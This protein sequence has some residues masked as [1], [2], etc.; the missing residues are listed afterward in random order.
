M[1]AHPDQ[2]RSEPNESPRQ[3]AR[4][5]ISSFLGATIEFYDFLLYAQAAVLAF[6]PV[7]FR[8]S[9]PEV[10][11][12]AALGTFATG[13]LARPLGGLVFGYFGDRLGRKKMLILS[14][15]TMGLASTAIGLIPPPTVIGPWA[16]VILV[17]LRVC[18]GIAVG[19]EWGGATLLAYEHAGVKRRGFLASFTQAGAPTGMALA[20]LMLGLFAYLP[21][22][23]FQSWGWRI[24]FLFSIVLLALCLFVR[25]GVNESPEFNTLAKR[26]A[27]GTPE[28]NRPLR[29]VFQ[30]PRP[31]L[32]CIFG[33]LGNFVLAGMLETF[34]LAY[35]V[36]AG[37]P[38]HEALVM[39]SAASVFLI[40]VT[41][42][43]GYLS[44]LVGRVRLMIIGYLAFAALLYPVFYLFSLADKFAVLGALLLTKVVHGMIYGPLAAFIADQFRPEIRYVG[45]SAGYQVASLLGNGLGPLAITGLYA[46]SGQNVVPVVAVGS[47][48]C[49]LSA[50]VVFTSRFQRD[51]ERRSP[52][53]PGRKCESGTRT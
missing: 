49:L 16:A 45:A 3:P 7:F 8:G 51:R 40:F 26:R 31:V 33:T 50:I 48:C 18:Q 37:T 44:D 6:G 53:I 19:G 35:A 41:V 47:G 52:S 29:D 32:I 13:Y 43:M 5:A 2:V 17:F 9:P 10:A 12:I 21:T 38:K 1:S 46:A 42:G 30:Q 34:G 14:M 25:A 39:W 28:A 11:T 23:E 36:S 4:A 24:P 22:S 20:S 27:E 15:M